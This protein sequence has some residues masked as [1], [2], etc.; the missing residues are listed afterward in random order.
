MG[1]GD[2]AA[3]AVNLVTHVYLRA[4]LDRE[5]AAVRTAPEGGRARALF[6]AAKSLGGLVGAGLLNGGRVESLLAEAASAAGLSDEEARSHIRRGLARGMAK[7]RQIQGIPPYR[8]GVLVPLPPTRTRKTRPVQLH[9]VFEV[10]DLSRPVTH[11]DEVASW[12]IARGLDP[13]AVELWDLCRALPRD[14]QLPRWAWTREGGTWGHS[15][16]RL[17]VRAR[18][19]AGTCI[20]LRARAVRVGAKP[21]KS[22]APSGA[23]AAGLVLACPL[24]VQVLAGRAPSWWVSPSFVIAEGEP[25]FLTWAARQSDTCEQGPAVLGVESGSWTQ[26]IADRIPDGA[27]VV[28][29]THA[30]KAGED[31][32]QRIGLTLA[33]RCEVLRLRQGAAT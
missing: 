8:P 25:D 32:A 7:P 33:G 14:A 17:L 24:A 29:R 10:W 1:R 23:K 3:R 9:G 21:A 26:E 20:A 22:L 28:I 12:L 11:D 13:V 4:A 6:Q 15:G 31:Y 18:N 27:R 5:L 2:H 16:H 30:D 19:A